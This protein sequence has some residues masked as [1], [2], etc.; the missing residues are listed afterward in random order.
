MRRKPSISPPG[1]KI[2]TSMK[3]TPRVSCQPSPTKAAV[4]EAARFC[5]PSGRKEK[6]SSI[7]LL[8]KAEKMFSKYLI[9]PAP[10]T[11]PRSVPAPPRMVISTTSP[12]AVHCM[13]SAPAKGSVQARS[14]PARPAYIPEITKALKA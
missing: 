13:R 8:L 11:G 5:G 1:R 10:I 2:T 14:P 6:K 9:A 4:T 3:S 7:W 12:E